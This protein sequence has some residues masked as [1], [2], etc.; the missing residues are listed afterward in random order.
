MAEA[1]TKQ[2]RIAC[3]GCGVKLQH[4]HPERPGYT[5]KSAMSREPVICQRCFRIKH[6]NEMSSIALDEDD[7]LR[8]LNRIGTASGLIVHIVDLFDLEG[9]LIGGLHRF[10]GNNPIVLAANKIDLFP[11]N[12]NRNRILNRVQKQVKEAGLK[13][14]EIVLCSAR[15][16]DGFDRLIEVLRRRPKGTDIYV[17]GATNV[18][19]STLINRLIR[20]YSDLD[21]ELTVSRYPGTTLDMVHIPLDDGNAIIDTPGIVYKFRLTEIVD[22]ADLAA[23]TP[24]KKIKPLVYQLN[25]R[26]TLFFG[27]LVRFDFVKGERQSFTCYVSGGFKVHRTK[28]E[29]ADDLYQEHKGELLRPPARERLDGLPEWTR[30]A[31]RIPPG[32]PKDVLISGLG[33]IKAN[34]SAGCELVVHAPKGVKVIV[35]DPMI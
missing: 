35:R 7:F 11:K 23:I 3:S 1:G 31:I 10:T 28:L 16:S 33:W 9:S 5:P 12:V 25:E 2:H 22:K 17:V 26:Q 27:A 4:D 14:Q 19:K 18:G 29:K 8:V 34:S 20:D 32:G 21:A 6:Y 15:R 30:H 13:P 24:D